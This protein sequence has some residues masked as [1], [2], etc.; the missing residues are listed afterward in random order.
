MAEEDHA[1]IFRLQ[2]VQANTIKLVFEGIKEILQD[3]NMI[4]SPTGLEI[5]SPEQ[6]NTVLV[7]M[8]LSSEAFDSFYC[9]E[10][11]ILVGLNVQLFYSLI[12]NIHNNDTLS[13]FVLRENPTKI[14]IYVDNGESDRNKMTRFHLNLL[15]IEE[16]NIEVPPIS[17]SAIIKISTTE[18][19]RTF[20]ELNSRYDTV[21]VMAV[22][23]RLI[24]SAENE[25]SDT[26]RIIP[27][28]SNEDMVFLTK[29]MDGAVVQGKFSL[30]HLV[31]FTKCANLN[32]TI[33]LCLENDKPIIIMYEAGNMGPLKFMLAQQ[34][35]GN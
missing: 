29:P 16:N 4:V 8:K 6:T 27:E 23:G 9:S 21:F 13:L 1:Y 34:R 28:N 2:T 10:P 20:R 24:M 15:H 35:S 25:T 18:L 19:Q 30:K 14:G 7:H 11:R 32:N 3:C 33:T 17:F 5:L 31:Q 22:N 26:E 12:R